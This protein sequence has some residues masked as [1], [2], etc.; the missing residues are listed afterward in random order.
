MYW[1]SE[2]IDICHSWGLK[3]LK[4]LKKVDNAVH[5]I[6]LYPLDRVMIGFLDT[7]PLDRDLS[8]G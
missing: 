7:Y 8:C 6:N 4:G 5:R 1:C 3:G 2:K